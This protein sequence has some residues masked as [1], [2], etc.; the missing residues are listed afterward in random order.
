MERYT[1]F[2][3]RQ[4]GVITRAQLRESGITAAAI[5]W[6]TRTGDLEEVLPAVYRM[7]GSPRT[8][9]QRLMATVLWGG[10]GTVASHKS[11]AALSGFNGFG[12]GPLE[13]STSKQNR[14]GLG[15]KGHRS[16]VDPAYTTTKV[17]IPVTNAFRT[18]R[19]MVSVVSETR[20]NQLFDELLRKGLVSM[21]SVRE[22]VNREAGSGNRGVAVL[23]KL[24]N[25]RDPDYQP[26][27]S[28]FQALVRRLLTAAGFAFVEEYEVFDSE[29]NF[30]GRADFKLLGV[31]VLVEAEG[32]ANHSSKADFE[33]DLGRRNRFTMAGLATV[34]V[35]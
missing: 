34:H 30:V 27:A 26:S 22:M 29:G 13:I 4:H 20:A 9:E 1:R 19:D 16:L 11:A 25:Q 24:V 21:A 18:L 33:R 8:W 17:G 35:T 31:P 2:A 5:R 28:E 6:R 15:F 10:P 12:P 14:A 32:R 3:T 23:R 7:A